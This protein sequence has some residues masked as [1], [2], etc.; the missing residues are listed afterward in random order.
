MNS[1]QTH[2]RRT[3]GG[4]ELDTLVYSEEEALRRPFGDLLRGGLTA[5]LDNPFE[6]YVRDSATGNEISAHNLA[7]TPLESVL[8]AASPDGEI[9]DRTFTVDVT[10]EHRGARSAIGIPL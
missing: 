1:N 9:V 2:I 4:R 6:V 5:G 8:R 7:L 3:R 10:V